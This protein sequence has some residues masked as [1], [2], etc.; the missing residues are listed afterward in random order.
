MISK[1]FL[2][3]LTLSYLFL[4][5][6]ISF[7]D[8]A[9]VQKLSDSVRGNVKVS[10]HAG[11]QQ[12]RFL[13]AP[14]S[15]SLPQPFS[16]RPDVLPE[17][18]A[19]SFLSVYGRLFGLTD[20][21]RELQLNRAREFPEGRS[22]VKFKQVHN[23]IPVIAGELIV[24]MD[25]ARNI[26]S[27][28][29]EMSPRIA[30]DTTPLFGL[31]RAQKKALVTVAKKYRVSEE[32]LELSSSELSIYNPVLLGHQMNRNFLVW[33]IIVGSKRV[34]VN[35]LIL[36]D[37]RTGVTLLSFNQ[38]DAALYREIYDNDNG[39]N[40]WDLPGYG[41]V[42]TEIVPPDGLDDPGVHYAFDYLGDTYNFYW[43]YHNRDSIDNAGMNMVATVRYCDLL[44]ALYD[45]CP[46]PNAYWD[47]SQ[48]VF[49]D[50]FAAADDVVGHE[51]THGVTERES[52]LFYY[53]QSGAI[54]ES[55]SDIWGEFIDQSNGLGK[56]GV[57]WNWKLGEDL[58][59]ST[60]VIR[61]MKNPPAY[62]DPDSMLSTYY[63]CKS[64]DNGGVHI[65]SGVNNK[66]AYL[67]TDGGTFNGYTIN[68]L[69]I[70]KV[71]K[72][73]YWV[74]TNLLTSGADYQD[75]ADA[76]NQACVDLIGGDGIEASDC[77]EV[78]KAVNAVHMYALPDKCKNIDAPLCYGGTVTDLFFDNMEDIGSGNWISGADTGFNAWYYPQY[79]NYL[80]DL[81]V[82]FDATYT[83]SGDYN[84]W[85]YDYGDGVSDYYIARTSS[86][87]VPES[88]NTFMHF[89]HA[90]EF[91][92]V[93]QSGKTYYFDG[94][95]LEY[96]TNNGVT[97]QDAKNFIIVNG[98]DGKIY[99]GIG[100]PFFDNPLAGRS[101]FVGSSHGYVSSKLDLASLAGQTVR[102]RFRIGTDVFG[103][104]WGWFIDDVR[105]YTCDTSDPSTVSLTYPSGSEVW[106]PGE[107]E[108]ITWTGPSR[109][110]YATLRYSLDKGATWKTI[111]KNLTGTGTEKRT[112]YVWKVP[113]QP[114]N[115]KGLLKVTGYDSK[116]ASLGSSTM[117]FSIEVVRIIYPNGGE[118]LTFGGD[119]QSITWTTNTTKAPIAKV[120]LFYTKNGGTTW[121]EIDPTVVKT[122]TRS[123]D[124]T[125]PDVGL[126][127]KTKC[128]VKVVLRDAANNVIG[129]DVSD[130]IFTIQPEEL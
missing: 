96:S 88:G 32:H 124:W 77:D 79:P 30:L 85:G 110:A 75:L 16:L 60:G 13:A 104:S 62:K 37:A 4:A 112:E 66:A 20:P 121:K 73:Y 36:I 98:Y 78:R 42:A 118:T 11:T 71:A 93:T 31:Q 87:T 105:I 34:P 26:K 35:Q 72:I 8:Q 52:A 115:K 24:N 22:V 100:D 6:S 15:A 29:G 89:N 92:Y 59:S 101:G 45:L 5:A 116:G 91:E 49:G 80:S 44:Y 68:P 109:M 83:T 18:A 128:K 63:Y 122:N 97:W 39:N 90:Y 55:F 111:E 65:N 64:G 23:G 119:T 51:L 95:I 123:Y 99:A 38:I 67:M 28:S 46:Y 12:V 57:D 76:L 43:T 117:P 41:P 14:P 127:A 113:L 61:N 7:A 130:T 70:E 114:N 9:L 126:T 102:F 108:T 19:K 107:N 25:R 103:D 54:N 56:D 53:M 50:G 84:I 1:K 74:Q 21:S 129:S 2:I 40:S 81:G 86:V 10:Y 33:K 48:M 69:R 17:H 82:D 58:P 125:V 3:I 47:G 94:G 106:K 27:I 120:Q